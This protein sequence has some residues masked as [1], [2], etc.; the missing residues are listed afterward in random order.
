MSWL[1]CHGVFIL[2][3]RVGFVYPSTV[4]VNVWFMW[5]AES[6]VGGAAVKAHIPW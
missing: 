3:A 4:L 5:E 6:E 2:P 1:A